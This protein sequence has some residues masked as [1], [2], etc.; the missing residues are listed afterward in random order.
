MS[1]SLKYVI[2]FDNENRQRFF[3]VVIENVCH[4]VF[5][6]YHVTD[7][8]SLERR[9]QASFEDNN[10]EKSMTVVQKHLWHMQ[11][12]NHFGETHGKK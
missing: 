12:G 2:E 11:K 5:R 3:F 4:L 9:I 8:M 1:S 7:M 10:K 6:G